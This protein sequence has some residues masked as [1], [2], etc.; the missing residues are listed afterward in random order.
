LTANQ[1]NVHLRATDFVGQNLVVEAHIGQIEGNMLRR[2]LL[3]G[4]RQL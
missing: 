1:Q 2:F 3:D 4:F